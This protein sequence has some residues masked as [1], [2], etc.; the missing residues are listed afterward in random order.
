MKKLLNILL[1]SLLVS[2]SITTVNAQ[3]E[4]LF[5][6]HIISSGWNGL[7]YGIALDVIGEV[8]GAA[9][10]GIPV[11]AAGASALLPLLTNPS[12]QI[13]YN[14]LV[15]GGHGRS[16]GWAHGFALAT[17][18]GGERAWWGNDTSSNNY[19]L[20]V[21]AGALTSIG[22]GILGHSL[23]KKQ[24]WSEGQVSLFRHYGWVMPFT[25]FS[26]MAA[27]SEEPRLF[28]GAVLL[29]G[30][31]GY[32]LAN[33]VNNW[34]EFTRGEV[35]ATQVLSALHLGLGYGLFADRVERGISSDEN[36]ADINWMIPAAGT[37]AGT[38]IGHFW[39]KNTQLTPQQ[40]L[41]TAYA[42]GGGAIIGLGIALL[43][44]SDEITPYYLIPYAT[45]TAA[46]AFML[47]RLRR[48]NRTQGYLPAGK[49]NN[50]EF[51]FMPQNLFLNNKINQR[52]YFLNG[53]YMGG[54]QPLFSASLK[55]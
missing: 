22:L 46:Y 8:D 19:K 4:I 41:F 30:A 53:R 38:L 42:A 32:L 23:G 15:L 13:Y 49:N 16:I 29:F 6:K 47:E 11:I 3:D 12:K 44:E 52:G 34:N 28:G 54:M 5:R 37:L 43:V 35:R 21:A 36:F 10:V 24:L 33:G 27:L 45:G 2:S 26:L 14:S 39:T 18:I 48:T 25:G 31:G 1:V 55:F 50:W 40:G 51:A 9:A 7:F 17:L 20:T